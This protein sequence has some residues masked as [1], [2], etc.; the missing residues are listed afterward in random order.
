MIRILK[1]FIQNDMQYSINELS[2]S[3]NI[4]TKTLTKDFKELNKYLVAS[5]IM[6]KWKKPFCRLS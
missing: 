4:S 1:V 5:R 2:E 6:C 3:L